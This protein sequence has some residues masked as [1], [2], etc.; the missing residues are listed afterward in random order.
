MFL[1]QACYAPPAPVEGPHWIAPLADDASGPAD[2]EGTPDDTAP[3]F[4]DS[5]EPTA[6]EDAVPALVLNEVVAE[7]RSTL[8]LPDGT[9]PDWIEV[10]NPTGTA[11]PLHWISLTDRSGR[12]WLGP[13]A[14]TLEPGA[15]L[16]V[17]ADEADGDDHA[18]FSLD[19][20]GD[21]VT[22]A[23]GGYVTDRLSTGAVGHDVAWARLP[24]G[25]D[26]A[27]TLWTTPDAANDATASP[28]LDPTDDVFQVDTQHTVEITLSADAIASLTADR[29]TYV[30]GAATLD[31]MPYADVGV[32][33][34]AYVG[35]SRTID[36]KCGFKIDLNRYLPG[37]EWKGLAKLTLNNMVQDNTYVHEYLAY[38]LWRAAGVPAPRVGY[39]RVF[40]NGVDYGLYLVIESV[41]QSFL[42]QWYSDT[43]GPLYEGA[44]GVDLY[45]GYEASFDYDQ[46]PDSDDRSDLTAVIDILDGEATDDAI[47]E[48]ETHVDLDEV[49]TNMAVEGLILHWDGYTTANNYRL[50][51]DPVTDKFQIIPWGA[52]QTFLTLYYGPWSGRGRLFTFCL[53]NRACAARYDQKLLDVADVM[54][55]LDLADRADDL[56]NWLLPDINSDPRREF[57]EATHEY[58]YEATLSSIETYPDTVRA[59]VYAR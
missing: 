20:D 54:D 21:D 41:D 49:L 6:A 47:A 45:D 1:L 14:G 23:V 16:L 40:V 56:H 36:Q 58:Y 30:E 27:P 17:Y 10:Y 11:V 13:A 5:A 57:S 31:G 59:E 44:Y 7:N 28:S 53:A 39:A 37:Q 3:A 51:H 8:V 19:S 22:L 52:D 29:L 48:L 15:R 55:G 32:R 42:S 18:P 50:Y 24:D 12:V 43:S 26:W 38:T 9:F 46:G 35:S 2:A 4:V 34:K 33:L 25:G